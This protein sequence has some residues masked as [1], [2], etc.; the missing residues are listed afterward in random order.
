MA[1]TSARWLVGCRHAIVSVKILPETL[2]V[3]LERDDLDRPVLERFAQVPPT[4]L[5]QP[6]AMDGVP[7]GSLLVKVNEHDF[8]KSNLSFEAVQ[9]IMRETIYLP[10]TLTFYVFATEESTMP[11]SEQVVFRDFRPREVDKLAKGNA[12]LIFE[13]D[14]EKTGVN[15]KDKSEDEKVLGDV[16]DDVMS[17][18]GETFHDIYEV[19]EVEVLLATQK[20][21][22]DRSSSFS[23]NASNVSD[24]LRSQMTSLESL[25][26]DEQAI[27]NGRDKFSLKLVESPIKPRNHLALPINSVPVMVQKELSFGTMA[28]LAETR[29]FDSDDSSDES[30]G[31]E[32]DLD[33]ELSPVLSS[34]A[35]NYTADLAKSSADFV[36]V[37]APPGLLG[38]HFDASI[39]NR[40]VVMGFVRL[41]DGSKSALERAGSVVPGSVIVRIDGE[42]VS[43][44]TLYEVG[45]KLTALSHQSRTIV[46]RVPPVATQETPH[47]NVLHPHINHHLT[48]L[49]K[50]IVDMEKRR[51]LELELIVHYDRQVLRR[52]DCWFCIDTK[53]MARWIN[54]V[55]H[56]GPEPGPIP[57]E[58]L[59]HKNWRK[60]L[61]QDAPGRPGKVREG[62]VLMKDYRV[63][64]P[65][66]WCLFAEL[67]GLSDAPSLAR[68]LMDIHAEALCDSDLSKVLDFWQP[69]AAG[70][71]NE[72]KDKC[73]VRSSNKR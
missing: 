72:L 67:H 33:E 10:R 45:L 39:L 3:R 46:F 35:F 66:V 44:M 22:D 43:N 25:K 28:K 8:I 41:Q 24:S 65:I 58:T 15:E 49:P 4:D 5:L 64:V 59:L 62:L 31:S 2:I 9:R 70:L 6:E 34:K 68:Y 61:S 54:F 30:D 27:H 11:P 12:A 53:W 36:T 19:K 29:H 20:Q 69:K 50:L 7:V 26:I 52:R 42:D 18:D 40:A 55:C 37:T 13:E 1:S 63:V 23:L 56:G 73:L 48:T 57:N 21:N 71:A 14:E 16:N 60:M 51:K 17:S 47:S 38:L 32:K